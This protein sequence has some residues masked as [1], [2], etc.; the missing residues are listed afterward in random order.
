M[1]ASAARYAHMST[2]MQGGSGVESMMDPRR[3]Q[4]ILDGSG[5][6]SMVD[7]RWIQVILD[8]SAFYEYY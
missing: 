8:G 3:G 1:H 6:G 4:V 7:P 5:V 2:A